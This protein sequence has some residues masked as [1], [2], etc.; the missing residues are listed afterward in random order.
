MTPEDYADCGWDAH[1]RLRSYPGLC[2]VPAHPSAAGPADREKL[3]RHAEL[4]AANTE[5]LCAGKCFS[6]VEGGKEL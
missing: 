4:V 3:E 2:T 6:R 1:G 5:P